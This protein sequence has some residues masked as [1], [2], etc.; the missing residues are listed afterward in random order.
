M[1]F[2]SLSDNKLF[3]PIWNL[4]N[5]GTDFDINFD[6]KKTSVDPPLIKL[7][8]KAVHNLSADQLYGYKIVSAV[9]DGVLHTRVALLETGQETTVVG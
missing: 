6:F 3:G 7:P 5:S 8:N 2:P 1:N 4:L 9:K